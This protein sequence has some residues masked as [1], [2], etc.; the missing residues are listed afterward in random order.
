MNRQDYENCIFNLFV[1][2]ILTPASDIQ[3]NI[4]NCSEDNDGE[5][6]YDL[7]RELMN[8]MNDKELIHYYN[9]VI[10]YLNRIDFWKY[11]RK[12]NE[13]EMDPGYDGDDA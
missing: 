1:Q 5:N 3:K 10:Q 13:C 12:D 2:T 6:Y 9:R 11:Y 7:L 8:A 4:E